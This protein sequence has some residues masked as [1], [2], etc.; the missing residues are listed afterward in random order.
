[1]SQRRSVHYP[2]GKSECDNAFSEDI[3]EVENIPGLIH[4]TPQLNRQLDR[5]AALCRSS[6]HFFLSLSLSFFLF[7]GIIEH[8]A[9]EVSE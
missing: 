1:M 6:S 4:R 2:N 7:E 5:N 9:S 8:S 3:I